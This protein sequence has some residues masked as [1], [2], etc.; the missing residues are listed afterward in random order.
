[1][2]NEVTII[3][4]LFSSKIVTRA[5]NNEAPPRITI[6]KVCSIISV[7]SDSTLSLVTDF[8]YGSCGFVNSQ[9]FAEFIEDRRHTT[10]EDSDRLLIVKTIRDIKFGNPICNV[11][12]MTDASI[13]FPDI[14]NKENWGNAI[15]EEIVIDDK[16]D[17]DR[18]LDL[19]KNIFK[20]PLNNGN[21][22]DDAKFIIDTYDKQ[23]VTATRTYNKY[24]ETLEDYGNLSPSVIMRPLFAKTIT[25]YFINK[26]H[27]SIDGLIVYPLLTNKRHVEI[28]LIKTSSDTEIMFFVKSHPDIKLVVC[29]DGVPDSDGKVTA[30]VVYD[31]KH[32]DEFGYTD[33]TER[34]ISPH[35]WKA[36][37]SDDNLDIIMGCGYSGG[38]IVRYV[39]SSMEDLQKILS[40]VDDVIKGKRVV[41][42]PI[43]YDIEAKNFTTDYGFE[44]TPASHL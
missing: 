21:E 20:F 7:L 25:K 41:S 34:L 27:D 26:Y 14:T 29:T 44:F 18:L 33:S 43:T 12:E 8:G 17:D 37:I 5:M 31:A 24:K 9:S 28:A 4:P 38:F 10:N 11:K 40:A 3:S 19:I 6:N 36:I 15:V 30:R 1:M 13:A 39:R 32:K 35:L 23:I 2:K 42:I 16:F 22:A